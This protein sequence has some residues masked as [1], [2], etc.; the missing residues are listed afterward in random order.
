MSIDQILNEREQTHGLYR[1][2]AGYAQAIK[3]LMRSSR[4]WD[5]LD[6]TQAQTLEVV[7]DK[8]AR[9]LCGDPSFADHWQDGAGYF[10]LVV[11]DLT[12]ARQT[13]IPTRHSD[14]P[15]DAP[16]FLTEPRP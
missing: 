12:A 2:V 15:L 10:E 9:I 6:V 3:T 13:S 4:N 5:R 14:E 7:A 8:V 1:E 11:R 16:A